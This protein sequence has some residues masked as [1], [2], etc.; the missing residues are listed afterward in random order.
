M[1]LRGDIR[2]SKEQVVIERQVHHMVRLVDD[3][4][5]VS[6]ITQGKIQLRKRIV[7]L[8][9]VVASAVEVAS[10]LLEQRRHQLKVDVPRTG[11]PVEADPDRLAQVITNLLTN[12]AKYTE[13]EGHIEIGAWHD[14]HELVVQVKDNGVGIPPTLLPHVFDLFVQGTRSS[15]RA[16]G[17]LGLG[18]TLVRN[19]VEMHHGTV[20]A[21][22]EGHG[23]GSAF[24][25]RLPAA[26]QQLL[27]QPPSASGA[28]LRSA[29]PRRVL[30]VDDNADAAML[31][32]EL[33]GDMGHD[34]RVAHDGP[35]ALEI[36]QEFTPEVAVLDIGLPVMDGYDLAKR[37]HD[38]LPACRLIALT[39]YGQEHD[40]RRS[41]S[42]GFEAHLVKPVD[43]SRVL[44]LVDGSD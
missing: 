1:K 15:D 16:L 24:V 10:P 42:V 3:L 12:A 27:A 9:E 5:D 34:V 26:P 28:S 14:G 35:Q 19:L 44:A 25:V 4:L 41:T 11:M 23:K 36:L 8:A 17:G 39:G 21:L 29:Q 6:R 2:S 43:P 31:L 22:S 33:C 13:P 40:R 37:I 20:V 7:E 30:V 18:L 38:Q 32:G